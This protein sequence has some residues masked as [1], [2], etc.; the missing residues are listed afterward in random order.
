MVGVLGSPLTNV[1]LS[2]VEYPVWNEFI[3]VKGSGQILQIPKISR[4]RRPS[5]RML[6]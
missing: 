2:I 5:W 1:S 6:S 4:V 3:I